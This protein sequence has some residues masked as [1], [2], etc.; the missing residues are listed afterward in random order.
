MSGTYSGKIAGTN[1]NI[2]A[3]GP[4]DSVSGNG[5]T[6]S[7]NVGGVNNSG[8][9]G[10][11]QAERDAMAAAAKKAEEEAAKKAEE[12]A[13]K[14]EEEAEQLADADEYD[15]ANA[16]DYANNLS[17]AQ[18]ESN[19][20]ILN[21]LQSGNNQSTAAEIGQSILSG[22]NISNTA[23]TAT[24]NTNNQT[25]SL[26]KRLTLALQGEEATDQSVY[27]S[28]AEKLSDEAQNSSIVSD[29][30]KTISSIFGGSK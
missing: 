13:K 24:T 5:Y 28:K 15:S 30:L 3:T 14:A 2:Q 10:P 12:A 29:L 18:N 1:P 6:Q 17:D 16:E 22:S 19:Q 4:T 21:T 20:N 7:G 27:L 8:S 26:L 23:D 25:N 9:Y 11:T